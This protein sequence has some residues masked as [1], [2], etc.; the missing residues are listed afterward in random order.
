[1][2][3]HICPHVGCHEVIPITQPYCDKHVSRHKQYDQSVRLTID[4][5]YHAFY[6]SGE[7]E[8]IKPVIDNKYHGICLWSYYHDDIEPYKAI[9]HIHPLREAWEERLSIDNLIPLTQ[10]AHAMVEVEYKHGNKARMQKELFELKKR[11]D[12]EFGG[13]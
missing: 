4:A 10:D 12:K 13:R 6:V 1:M 11:W 2:L 9:H 7:W 3:M 8:S 5:K